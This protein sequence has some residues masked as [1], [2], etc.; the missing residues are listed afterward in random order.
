MLILA[1]RAL[2]LHH[3]HLFAL[4]SRCAIS[5]N[6]AKPRPVGTTPFIRLSFIFISRYPLFKQSQHPT[7][8]T[9]KFQLCSGD[10]WS[11][12]QLINFQICSHL[13]IMDNGDGRWRVTAETEQFLDQFPRCSFDGAIHSIWLLQCL[14]PFLVNEPSNETCRGFLATFSP[15]NFPWILQL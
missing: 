5:H 10:I 11:Y 14:H 4:I 12:G 1:P 6:P 15:I 7:K 8:L 13:S 2:I 3:I 9:Q